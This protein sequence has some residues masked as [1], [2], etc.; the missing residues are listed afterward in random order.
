MNPIFLTN[1][2]EKEFKEL[3]KG[4]LREVLAEKSDLSKPQMPEIFGI[5]EAA[6]FL[7][8]SIPTIYG[9]TAG[10]QIPHFKKGK[11]LY[12]NRTELEAWVQEGKVKTVQEIEREASTYLL[13]N[14]R[15]W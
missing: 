12:F 1:L 3:L 10:R 4:A 11:R 5:K 13:R 8:L 6:G 7:R 2:D 14:K 9:K 15:K